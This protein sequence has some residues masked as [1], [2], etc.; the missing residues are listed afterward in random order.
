MWFRGA[1]LALLL[2]FISSNIHAD[3]NARNVILFLG[4]AGGLPTLSA[5]SLYAHNE[6]QKLFIQSMPHVALSETSA[7]DQ[8]VTDSAAGMTAIVTGEKTNNG[9]LSLV[10]AAGGGA[11]RSVKTIL[12]YAE[13]RGL[14][15]AIVTNMPAWDAT[16][17][18]CYAHVDSRAKSKEIYL[19]FLRPRYG[20]GVDI[21]VGRGRRLFDAALEESGLRVDRTLAKKGYRLLDSPKGLTGA[22]NRAVA[23][24][25][26]GEFDPIPVVDATLE[27]LS[28]NPKGYFLMVEW[29]MHPFDF[30]KNSPSTRMALDHAAQMDALIRH[31]STRV[32]K[33]TLIMFAA[34]HSLGVRLRGGR[35]DM[36]FS[37][38]FAT[39]Q[40]AKGTTQEN[41]PLITVDQHHTGE[42]IVV[43]AM[44]PGSERVR[45][46]MPNTL[47]FSIMMDAYGWGRDAT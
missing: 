33:D 21:L 11:P 2:L 16:P 24:Y 7:L 32:G 40:A 29:D 18:A 23:L 47:L 5:A 43:T 42:E 12:E 14:A 35:R 4:D 44:G 13:E 6:P 1:R 20:D 41:H 10:P 38:Q 22:M 17:A 36:R 3:D 46:F 9:M 28:R 25:D 26:E 37:E 15:T 27:S 34:D 19:Q 31:V 39:A 30:A 8:W 45:G